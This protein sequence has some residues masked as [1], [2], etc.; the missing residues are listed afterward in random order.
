MTSATRS[1]TLGL[2]LAVALV[3]VGCARSSATAGARNAATAA[4]RAAMLIVENDNLTDVDVFIERGRDTL[5]RVGTVT[6]ESAEWFTI[7]EELF[8]T[9]T[10]RLLAR[11]IG[12][13]GAARSGPVLV[14][15][16]QKVTFRIER[17]LAASTATVR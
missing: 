8:P 14:S 11:P 15:P 5:R 12:G 7:D 1:W 9:G 2:T 4:P 10:L 13:A 3:T 17:D 6:G 16:G